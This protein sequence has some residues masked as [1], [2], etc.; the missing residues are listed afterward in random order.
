MTT[1]TPPLLLVVED[2]ILLH[3]P[4]K[5]E[6]EDAGYNPMLVTNGDRALKEL[7]RQGQVFRA[8]VTDIRLGRGIDGWEVAHRAREIAPTL[9]VIYMSVD[10]ASAWAANGV[11]KSVMLSKPFAMAQLVTAISQLITEADMSSPGA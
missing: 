8:L 9:P 2:E 7:K 10:S 3:L 1:T 5:D 11:P 6:L 4:L